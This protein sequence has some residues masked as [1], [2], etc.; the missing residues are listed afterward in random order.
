MDVKSVEKLEN[1]KVEMTIAV[2]GEEFEAAIEK[3]F[4]KQR[5]SIHVPGFRKGH[6]P[7][8]VIEGMYGAD[9]FYSDAVNASYPEYYEQALAQ[10]GLDS[11]AYTD[12]T[13]AEMGK[14][15]YTFKARLT[16][17][18]EVKLGTY[19]GVVV[20]AP[21]LTV[22]EEDVENELKLY[23]S[24]ATRLVSVDRPAKKW[25]SVVIDFE[26]FMDGKP[27]EG[28][29]ADGYE[30]ELGSG[31]FIPGFEDKLIGTKAGDEVD[32]DLTFP[33]DYQPELAG[34]PVLFK[35]KVNEVKEKSLPEVDDEF[36]KD[37]SEFETL[38][39]FK[40]DL[41]TKAR[42]GKEAQ[43]KQEFEDAA[44]KLAVDGME[45]EIPEDM[46]KYQA[47]RLF[48]SFQQRISAQGIPFESYVEMMGMTVDALRA[49]ANESAQELV[50]RELMLHAV[51]QAEGMSISDEELEQAY[52]AIAAEYQ[53]PM[54]QVKASVPASDICKD[55]LDRKAR[56]FILDHAKYGDA[57]VKD[58]EEAEKLKAA[59]KAGT[60]KTAA[61]Q[62]D[63]E[64]EPAADTEEKPKR[65]KAAKKTDDTEAG[66]AEAKSETK[67]KPAAKKTA[68]AAPT[69]E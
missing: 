50:R 31:S 33:E 17:R 58:G 20:P 25:D 30:L 34:R 48:N 8:K 28:G 63:T 43:A 15:G 5:G 32:I 67:K 39:E 22:T 55:E 61:K 3:V 4:K 24:R 35:V 57:P 65:K 10:S 23:V 68:K 40:K 42:E 60:K 11:V 38:A 14:D 2:S 66:A 54:E 47:D 19:K 64:A 21:D 62:A 9:L 49:Q 1:N 51:A 53:M 13:I 52:A 29:Q 7:R 56:Q 37:V 46:V 59:K 69:E 6:A 12:V 44:I 45:A 36:A 16:V 27:F 18:P 41:E 26:G